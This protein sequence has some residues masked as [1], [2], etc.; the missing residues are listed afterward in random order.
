MTTT[1]DLTAI[2]YSDWMKAALNLAARGAG[3]VQSNPKVGAIVLDAAGR[4]AGTG[5]HER[6]GGP[7][8][9]VL[10]LD[11]A[12]DLA[13]G[14]T[15]IVTLEP[16]CHTGRTPP[17]TQA[18]IRSGIERVVAADA[19]PD[20]R[21]SGRGF[22]Q[23]RQ[24]GIDVITGVEAELAAQLNVEY[25]HHRRTGLPW[26][27]LKLALSLDGRTADAAGRSQWISSPACRAHAHGLRGQHEAILVGAG[28]ALADD[29]V[30]SLH[31]APG[32]AP[33]RFVLAGKRQLPSTLRLFQGDLPATRVGTDE[34][35]DWV[36]RATALGLP[37]PAHVVKRMGE[38]GITSLLVEGGSSVAASFLQA[39]LVQRAVI[40]YGPMFLG[41]GASAFPGASFALDG[42]PTLTGMMIEP[43]QGGLVV[44]GRVEY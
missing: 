30:L 12:G 5:Y 39:R 28:T 27:T 42:A 43:L 25:L 34:R 23:L 15:L 11:A 17:C 29:P 38:E 3:F 36:V 26:V 32:L 10:A 22:D 18:I 2:D 24:A 8:A 6:A 35:A 31:G 7:H 1:L 13:R 4:Q 41:E 37:D 16:C 20:A 33:K 40:Y 19:D 9:E 14:G 44:W 21:V